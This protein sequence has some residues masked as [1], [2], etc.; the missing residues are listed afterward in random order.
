VAQ[1]QRTYLQ[2]AA[3]ERLKLNDDLRMAICGSLDLVLEKLASGNC[4]LTIGNTSRDS[5][6]RF[7][8]GHMQHGHVY[9]CCK[10]L[11]AVW[12]AAT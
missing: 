6:Q 5:Q 9:A 1:L 11:A 2:H 7:I 3:S 10:Q 8:F 4:Q 12:F